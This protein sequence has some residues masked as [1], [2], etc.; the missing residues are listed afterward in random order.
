MGDKGRTRTAPEILRLVAREG[1]KSK[2]QMKNLTGKSY[3][4]IH[5]TV[6][7]LL[8]QGLIRKEATRPSKRNP[9]MEVEYYSLT[10]S[11]LISALSDS[12]LW[13]DVIEKGKYDEIEA[14]I[15]RNRSL[16]P[17]FQKWDH[18]SR[19][20]QKHEL[21]SALLATVMC[22]RTVGDK[23]ADL[24]DAFTEL[25]FS[26]ILEPS[27]YT[28]I[29]F[30]VK[31]WIKA[32]KS[33]DYLRNYILKKL[34]SKRKLY[35]QLNSRTETLIK[36]FEETEASNT[37]SSA[38]IKEEKEEKAN[39]I[40]Q[41]SHQIWKT[42][43][44]YNLGHHLY[45]RAADKKLEKDLRADIINSLDSIHLAVEKSFWPKYFKIGLKHSS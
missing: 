40:V 36:Q 12:R 42:R 22:L 35:Q 8:A 23:L 24:E 27:F 15:K 37:T 30:D 13:N 44:F 28:S 29:K 21:M 7:E 38:P 32:I 1:P 10:L 34:K 16:H 9:K 5:Q 18:L 3:G 17:I 31:G 2:W 43:F 41:F 4:N 6:K 14:I 11:G 25:F 26:L 45:M 39:P 19:S 33:D 20:I